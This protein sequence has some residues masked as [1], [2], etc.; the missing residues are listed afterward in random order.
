MVINTNKTFFTFAATREHE[1]HGAL[2]TQADHP[3]GQKEAEG[4]ERRRILPPQ[5]QRQRPLHQ[6][7]SN[8]TG[9][10]PT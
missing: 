9:R 8:K 4:E 3:P 6:I 1:V 7:N 2:Q 10:H 5:I